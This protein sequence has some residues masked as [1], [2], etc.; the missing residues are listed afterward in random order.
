MAEFAAKTR[1]KVMIDIGCNTGDYSV[2]ALEGGA[3][4]VVGFDFDQRALDLA[5]SR[6]ETEKL[7]F[8]PLW[9]DASNPSPDQ[10]WMQAERAGFGE[11]AKVDARGRSRIRASSRDRQECSAA[12]GC[13]LACRSCSRRG[14]RIRAR[15]TTRP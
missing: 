14:D 3:S 4:Y 2:A 5:F 6:S 11:R 8:L 10:G 7:S 13:R 15:R 9:L 12:S 1:P